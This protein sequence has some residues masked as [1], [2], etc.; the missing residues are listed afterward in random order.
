MS[1]R[2]SAALIALLACS[3]GVAADDLVAPVSASVTVTSAQ[4]SGPAGAVAGVPVVLRAEFRDTVLDRPHRLQRP[5]AFLRPLPPGDVSTC[6]NMAR[7][8][9]ATGA[10][11]LGDIALDGYL[12]ALLSEGARIAVVDPQVSLATSN[13]L[14][15]IDL[16]AMPADFV[17]NPAGALY[18]S[19]P[20]RGE[21]AKIDPVS[22]RIERIASG[23]T[24]PLALAPT[25][26]GI[27]VLDAGG[28]VRLMGRHGVVTIDAGFAVTGFTAAAEGVLLLRG[29]DGA[30]ALVDTDTGRLVRR[31][32][33]GPGAVAI[34]HSAL[35]DAILSV[36]RDAAEIV[37]RF[38]DSAAPLRAPIAR[39]ADALI[40]SA[41]GRYAIAAG[42]KAGVASIVDLAFAQ[43]LQ[44][45]A[46]DEAIVDVSITDS[47]VFFLLEGR[48]SVA[49]LPR[50]SIAKGRAPALRRI[51]LGRSGPDA[52]V[53]SALQALTPDGRSLAVVSPARDALLRIADAGLHASASLASVALKGEAP[54]VM[55]LVP[56]AFREVGPG[57]YE[58]T[59][60]FAREGRHRLAVFDSSNTPLVCNDLIVAAG[61]EPV[62]A[63]HALAGADLVVEGL[64]SSADGVAIRFGLAGDSDENVSALVAQSLTSHWRTVVPVE[65]A[66]GQRF[67]A[68]LPRVRPGRHVVFAIYGDGRRSNP[69]LLE[70]LP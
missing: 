48:R 7:A 40:V 32:S 46:F 25:P 16:G 31:A 9:R 62:Q 60:S 2:R 36:D 30:V 58:A 12:V 57:R 55:R 39:P 43:T 66:G 68:A 67:Q 28:S 41:D 26:T 65:P 21:V 37:F 63:A 49:M 61:A 34:A 10:L 42:L 22:G 19:F 6:A 59:A 38:A 54:L 52:T 5:R 51:A 64:D 14:R 44:A 24:G 1:P 13:V 8:V 33:I 29:R 15:L 18:A 17:V 3:T 27:A 11:S 69:A 50:E 35:A 45:I 47:T 53:P 4:T 20:E 23:L 70:I 56:R